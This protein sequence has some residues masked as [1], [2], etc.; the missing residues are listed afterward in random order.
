MKCVE[1]IGKRDFQLEDVYAFEDR[2]SQLY[3]DNR[4]IRPKIRQQLQ[5]LRDL[6][7]LDFVSRGY[8]RVKF[9]T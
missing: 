9:E 6:D 2:L 3:P 1:A 8:Y 7:Y 5:F 4:N